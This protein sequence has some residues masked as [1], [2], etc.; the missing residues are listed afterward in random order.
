VP[1]MKDGCGAKRCEL[2]RTSSQSSLWLKI[3]SEFSTMMEAA[4][5]E[6]C[7][8]RLPRS[9]TYANGTLSQLPTLVPR[10]KGIASGLWPTPTVFHALR[11]NH[12]E[13]L[14]SYQKRVQDHKDGKTKGKPGPS[15][16]VAVRMKSQAAPAWIP[17]PCCDTYLCTIHDKHVHD[18]SCPPIEEWESSPY[19]PRSRKGRNQK[20]DLPQAARGWWEIEPDVGRMAHGIPSRVDRLRCLGNAVVPQV[21]EII[22]RAIMEFAS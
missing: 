12:D 16:G 11:G 20:Q 9:G 4:R 3:P 14:E 1:T 6:D 18:C 10:T 21:V 13:P 15:L 7:C 5:S 2:L 17:C 19:K 22:G 8:G